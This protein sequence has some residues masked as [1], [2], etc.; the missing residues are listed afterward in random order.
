L[1]ESVF[2]K[3]RKIIIDALQGGKILTRES[4]YDIL[5]KK[6]ISTSN[7]R[8]LHITFV[9]AQEQVICFGPRQGRQ[10]TFTLLDEWLPPAKEILFD[11]A[12]CKLAHSYF[13]S[14]GPAT[15]RDLAWWAG[16]TLSEAKTGLESVKSKLNREVVLGNEY[17]FSDDQ[18]S[19][20]TVPNAAHFMSV[21]DEYT[22]AYKDRSVLS[23][24]EK[25]SGK[26]FMNV[27]MINGRIG[28]TWKRTLERDHVSIEARPVR[29]LASQDKAALEKTAK[30]FGNFLCLSPRLRIVKN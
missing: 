18:P 1:D 22:I 8:G 3:S 21:Y 14:H 28:G 25:F 12:L 16:L 5:E 10:Q 13:T 2:R 26:A 11:E 4:L 27:F 7:V 20:K 17:W 29:P 30:Q 6:K 15:I 23:N 24:G 19:G 9:L